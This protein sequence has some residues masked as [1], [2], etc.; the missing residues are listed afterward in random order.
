M[1]G[2]VCSPAGVCGTWSCF[3]QGVLSNQ[4]CTDMF[5]L[6]L[7]LPLLRHAFLQTKLAFQNRLPCT[8]LRRVGPGHLQIHGAFLSH[9][10]GL[11]DASLTLDPVFERISFDGVCDY[12]EE[13]AILCLVII[14]L[15]DF[16]VW[17]F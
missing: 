3:L 9:E 6:A 13:R 2:L 11:D 14:Q 16:K 15:D 5:S 7:G 10:K 4:Q 1:F 17:S 8:L 12:S